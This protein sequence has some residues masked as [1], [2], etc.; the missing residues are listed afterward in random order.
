MTSN[1]NAIIP[2]TFVVNLNALNNNEA[3]EETQNSIV[4][5]SYQITWGYTND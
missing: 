4:S 3:Y 2:K 5:M 1:I